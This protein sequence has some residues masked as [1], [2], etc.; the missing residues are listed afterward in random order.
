MIDEIRT[1]ANILRCCVN[2]KA[3]GSH[4]YGKIAMMFSSE[5]WP[6]K[7]CLFVCFT[8]KEIKQGDVTESVFRWERPLR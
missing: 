6:R 2:K 3:L 1:G 8:M 5:G 4:C 7:I